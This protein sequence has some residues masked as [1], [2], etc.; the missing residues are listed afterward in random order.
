[1]TTEEA[2]EFPPLDGAADLSRATPAGRGEVPADR[3]KSVGFAWMYSGVLAAVIALLGLW[4]D[5]HTVGL[6]AAILVAV[7]GVVGVALIVLERRR[8][9]TVTTDNDGP[10]VWRPAGPPRY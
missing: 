1:M 4:L 7:G 9:S 8:R 3:R 10:L 6:V 5:Q 2:L